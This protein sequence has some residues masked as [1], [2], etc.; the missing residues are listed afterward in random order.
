MDIKKAQSGKTLLKDWWDDVVEY[1]FD[2]LNKGLEDEKKRSQDKD[3]ELTQNLATEQ[4]ERKAADT[5][6]KQKISDK[7]GFEETSVMSGGSKSIDW[8]EETEPKI[9]SVTADVDIPVGSDTGIM[10]IFKSHGY[11]ADGDSPSA[12]LE[13]CISQIYI[14]GNDVYYREKYPAAPLW[15]DWSKLTDIIGKLESLATEDKS[16]IV[17]AINEVNDKAGTGGDVDLSDYAT[18]EELEGKA[19]KATA[20]GG[21]VAGEGASEGIGANVVIGQN[22]YGVDQIVSIGVNAKATTS[23]I[24]IGNNTNA[25]GFSISIGNGASAEAGSIQIGSGNNTEPN[26][27]Q[28]RSYQLLDGTGHIPSER[29]PQ[30]A[31]KAEKTTISTSELTAPTL[32]MSYNTEVRYGE[33]SSLTLTLPSSFED[34]YIS[35]VVFTSGDTAVNLI[36]PE[37]IKISGEDCMDGIFTPV[38]NKRYTLILSYDG[39]YVSGIVGGVTI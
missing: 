13:N 2:T 19:D 8:D 32:N 11:V 15:N 27:V 33:V 23:S 26:T 25:S 16:S 20:N 5:S 36:Y 34:D 31:D 14:T 17:A 29:I 18:K 28:V 39:V 3:N 7:I 1:N 21:F 9:Y 12:H 37:E 6:L 35:S 22:A 38:E 4:E 30:L 10:I 24:S